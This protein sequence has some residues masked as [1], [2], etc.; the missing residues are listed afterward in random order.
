MGEL[1]ECSDRRRWWKKRRKVGRRCGG[2]CIATM[3]KGEEKRRVGG[4]PSILGLKTDAAVGEDG[5]NGEE[6]GVE[7]IG[8]RRIYERVFFRPPLCPWYG[9]RTDRGGG[10]GAYS[11]DARLC[12]SEL[13]P[14]PSDVLCVCV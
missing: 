7:A 2:V 9:S 13:S 11:G 10:G 1:G 14:R 12:P 8:T 4:G 3:T 5:W 6:V